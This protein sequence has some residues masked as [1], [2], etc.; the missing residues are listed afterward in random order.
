MDRIHEVHS[1]ERETSKGTNVVPERL[2]KMQPTTRP[3]HVWPE[4]RSRIGKAAQKERKCAIEKPKLDNA[5]NLRGI[6]SIESDDEEYK[7][8]IKDAMRKL[9]R[10]MAAAVPCKRKTRSTCSPVTD[11][12][13]EYHKSQ[14]I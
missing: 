11:R 12:S 2:T 1:V 13:V 6:Y 7:D 9:E 10:H 14:C 4:A 8:I 5:R 3:D